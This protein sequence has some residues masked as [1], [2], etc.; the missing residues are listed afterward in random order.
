VERLLAERAV[1]CWLHLYHLETVY[2]GKQSM[3]L[4]LGTYYQKCLDRAHKRYLT[5]LKALAEVRKLALPVLQ[6]NIARKQVNVAC[7]TATVN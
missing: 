3:T 5:A 6:L 1:A 2:A 7:G 4:D